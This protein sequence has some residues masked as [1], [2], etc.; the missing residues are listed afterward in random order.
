LIDDSDDRRVNCNPA[1][2]F[3]RADTPAPRRRDRWPSTE[4]TLFFHQIAT[5]LRAP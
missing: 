5:K 4:K 1:N 2:L 3:G